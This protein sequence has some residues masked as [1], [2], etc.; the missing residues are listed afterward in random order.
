MTCTASVSILVR[1]SKLVDDVEEIAMERGW[2][3]EEW[4]LLPPSRVGVVSESLLLRYSMQ[5]S[6]EAAKRLEGKTLIA[7]L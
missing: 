7:V 3:G 4:F 1:H 2:G 6:T 5:P